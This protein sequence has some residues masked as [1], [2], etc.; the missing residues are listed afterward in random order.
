DHAPSVYQLGSFLEKEI[1]DCPNQFQDKL[2]AVFP[3]SK[4]PRTI[5]ASR[6]FRAFLSRHDIAASSSTA[7]TTAY[8]AGQLLIESLQDAGRQPRREQL[9]H[10]LE[11][12]YKHETGLTPPLTF[13]P[14]RRIGAYGAYLVSIDL[15]TKAIVCKDRWITPRE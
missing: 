12:L 8:C 4:T 14:N 10:D 1:F 2:F 3:N 15:D 11:G 7:L 5:E 9:I 6:A 13:G